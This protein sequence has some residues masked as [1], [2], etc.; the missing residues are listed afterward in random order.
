MIILN[1]QRRIKFGLDEAKVFVRYEKIQMFRSVLQSKNFVY[2]QCISGQDIYRIKLYKLDL[3]RAFIFF[4][5]A[6]L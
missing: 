1:W 6:N 4:E 3:L 2:S 5:V